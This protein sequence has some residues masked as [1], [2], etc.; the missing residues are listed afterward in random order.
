MKKET[1]DYLTL[2]LTAIA[3]V[4]ITNTLS[5]QEI[6][7]GG[8]VGLTEELHVFKGGPKESM[9]K[10]TINIDMGYIHDDN[11]LFTFNMGIYQSEPTPEQ[12][13]ITGN[14]FGDA[15]SGSYFQNEI[16]TLGVG[17]K[18]VDI[19][20]VQVFVIGEAGQLTKL[21]YPIYK[22][23]M[24]ILGGTDNRY[25]TKTGDKENHTIIGGGLLVSYDNKYIKVSGT[26]KSMN[27]CVGVR[28]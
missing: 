16:F 20:G 28:L 19:K 26:D 4:F 27:L 5:A 10:G 6:L 23:P 25:I 17:F 3:F 7:F 8:G 14:T 13:S 24:G 9:D 11:M 22:D 15:R 21:W 2:F 18:A 1:K 12:Y